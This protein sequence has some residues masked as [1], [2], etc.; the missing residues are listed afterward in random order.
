MDLEQ[1]A[2]TSKRLARRLTQPATPAAELLALLR[3][4]L[5][6]RGYLAVWASEPPL[7]T[8]PDTAWAAHGFTR[9]GDSQWKPARWLPAWLDTRGTAPDE[10]A[11][12]RAPRRPNWMLDADQF[13]TDITG[14]EQYLSPGQK[15]AVRAVSAAEPGDSVICVLPTGSGKTD[16]VLTRALRRRPLQTCLV[17]PTVALAIDLERRARVMAGEATA[18][19]TYH[20][21][22]GDEA[23]RELA[24]RFRE[25]S[26]WLVIASPEAVCTV[27]SGPLETAAA[28]GRL[29]LVAIDEAHIVAEWG[30]DFRPAFQ[31][32]AGLLARLAQRAPVGQQPVTA[33]LTATLDNHGLRTLK[34]LFP[35]R[36]ELVVSAQATR[37]EPSWWAI[38]CASEDD[39][40]ARF[41][42]ACRHLPRP[43]LVYT[44][45]HN[46][47]RSTNVTTALR[48]LREAG[49]HAVS[50]VSGSTRASDRG[51]VADGLRMAGPVSRDL[52]VV[53]A[54]S[55]FGLGVDLPDVRGVVHLCLPESIDRLYQEVGRSGRDGAASTSLVLW[56][57]ADADMA[58]GLAD[59]R[60]IGDAKAWKRWRSMRAGMTGGPAPQVDLTAA[61]DDV[62]YPWSD[63]NRYWN[64][65]TL[66]GMARA[67]MI[68]LDWPTPPQVPADC[69]D[70]QLENIFAAHRRT[71]AVR[72]LD[73]DLGDEAQFR[74]RFRAGQSTARTAGSAS[75]DSALSLVSGAGTCV[76]SVLAEHY[77][78]ASGTS[79][80]DAVRQCGGCPA[81]RAAG[82]TATASTTPAE[83]L[84]DGGLAVR[85][86]RV[87]DGLA[88][89]GKLCVWTD[90][91]QA[92]AED[93]L[94]RRLHA[95]GVVAF[96][97]PGLPP[98]PAKTAAG[99]WWQD[100]PAELSR[101]VIE[102]LRVPT[103]VRIRGDDWDPSQ[104]GLLLSRLAPGPLTVVLTTRDHP[105]PFDSRKLLKESWGRQHRIDHLLRRL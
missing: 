64:L 22:L 48:W 34:R 9:A 6:A 27:L 77:R 7:D 36:H 95:A 66:S 82:R 68:A 61:T 70:E 83:A 84:F 90:G 12:Q 60:L 88:L 16:V 31:T 8:I 87:L 59:A 62:T 79:R 15:A 45:L 32:L 23:K 33:M 41:L 102:A 91:D 74:A 38:K 3:S 92:D 2:G 76:N 13:Y 18:H 86:R 17:V 43:L 85:P 93:E 53:V 57:D 80:L 39:K 10:A 40:R 26:Q 78:L 14:R 98:R 97:P 55:A 51:A 103:L 72:I 54:T 47:E 20:G 44:T 96:I 42:E 56:T 24:I 73:S 94:I 81:C 29:D 37:P 105:S 65:Q 89:D 46:S 52:D 4:A 19:F 100:Q 28:E 101:T 63:A 1:L 69:T 5:V 104:A 58:R 25:G 49:Y 21:Q 75:L 71:T 50:G 99:L 11:A 35:G 30:D 67:G